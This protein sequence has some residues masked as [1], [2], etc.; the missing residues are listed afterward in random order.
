[1][2]IFI[3]KKVGKLVGGIRSLRYEGRHSAQPAASLP[4]MPNVSWATGSTRAGG[5]QRD[6]HGVDK[7]PFVE[8]V[9]R[10]LFS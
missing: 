8:P 1:M 5:K 3:I 4:D 9:K 2:D 7:S 10:S 6:S